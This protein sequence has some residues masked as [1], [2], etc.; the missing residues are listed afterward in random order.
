M[1][2]HYF[3]CVHKT[4][5]PVNNFFEESLF[6]DGFS[7]LLGYRRIGWVQFD[8]FSR[9]LPNL[10]LLL[11]IAKLAIYIACPALLI[12]SLIGKTVCRLRED[13]KSVTKEKT[14][15]VAPKKEPKGRKVRRFAGNVDFTGTKWFDNY[16]IADYYRLLKDRFP[17]GVFFDFPNQYSTPAIWRKRFE[18]KNYPTSNIDHTKRNFL[19]YQSILLPMHISGNH[20]TLLFIDRVKRTVEYYDS[21][22]SYGAYDKIVQDCQGIAEA[23]SQSDPGDTPYVFSAKIKK[24]LQPDGYQCG[25]WTLYFS[26]KRLEN[27]D[28]DFNDLNF[29]EAQSIPAQFRVTMT[30]EIN[31]RRKR[32]RERLYQTG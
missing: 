9:D 29:N 13:D 17:Q 31:M 26:E 27:P 18:E 5:S 4:N 8:Q 24:L 30:D 21:K 22:V 6:L 28:V 11:T 15:Q 12:C 20:F 7:Q 16:N 23:L 32:L 25:P 1:N 2:N 3:D 10:R 19:E 14:E